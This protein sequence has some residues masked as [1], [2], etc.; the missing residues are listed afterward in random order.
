MDTLYF[1]MRFLCLFLAVLGAFIYLA[2]LLLKKLPAESF[3][4]KTTDFFVYTVI[5]FCVG[6][7]LNS[8]WG[9]LAFLPLLLLKIWFHQFTS[10]EKV[11]GSGRWM[12]VE[13][14][15]FTPRGFQFP[16]EAMD[17]LGKLPGNKHFMV[18]RILSLWALNYFLKSLHGQK[19]KSGPVPMK[20]Q[21][22]Q[23]ALD[24]IESK[25]RGIRELGVA[26]T[27]RLSLPFGELKVTRL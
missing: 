27:E 12:E 17:Q 16:Q 15:R 25:V 6:L 18:P 19:A 3:R 9:L 8:Y 20:P 4:L 2:M 1:I 7:G 10:K 24:L 11:R 21:Q 13:W 22:Q 26:S 5:S 23:Q 14:K